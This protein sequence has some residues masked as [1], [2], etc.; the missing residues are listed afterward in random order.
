MPHIFNSAVT[1][2]IYI[3]SSLLTTAHL[4]PP[5][6]QHIIHQTDK[7]TIRPAT[8]LDLDDIT[9]VIMDA[10]APGQVY[11]YVFPQLDQYRQYHWRCLRK[12]V[13]RSLKYKEKNDFWNVIAVPIEETANFAIQ[14]RHER[15]VAVGVWDV[16]EPAKNVVRPGMISPFVSRMGHMSCSDHLDVNI[17]RALDY[18]RQ[19]GPA[20]K[21]YVDDYPDKQ[22]YLALLATHPDWD[23]HDFAATHI[24]WGLNMAAEM[25][26]MTT[27]IATPAGWKLYNQLGFDSVA[28]I[29][30]T[31]IDPEDDNLWF[32]YM[33]YR[34]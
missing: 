25:D 21:H 11:R 10:F 24:Q 9:T 23:G 19:Y 8:E 17:T 3:T 15:V 34:P 5:N 7:I 26:L 31:T 12:D 20:E 14:G 32:E 2:L 22:V 27:L 30:I 18:S 28:N 33:Q 1:W 13:G 6:G 29:T 16:L 4:L